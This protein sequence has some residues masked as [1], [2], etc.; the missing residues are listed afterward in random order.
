MATQPTPQELQELIRLYQQ[1]EG[2]TAS[3]ADNAAQLDVNLG[4]VANQTRRLLADLTATGE[5]FS[6]IASALKGSIQEF[7]KYNTFASSAKKSFSSLQSITSRLL[8][9]QSGYNRLSEKEIVNLKKKISLETTNLTNLQNSVNLTDEQKSEVE[10]VLTAMVE[11][12][13]LTKKR[14]EKEKEISK[15][16][17]ITGNALKALSKIPGLSNALDTEEA[18]EDM[19]EYADTLKSSGKDITSF[20]NK[21]KIAGKGFST[22][23]GGLKTSLKDP[24]SLITFFVA[25]AFK[26][27]SQAVELGKSL[28][29][30]GEGFRETLSNIELANSNINVTTE[31]LTKAFSEL[32]TSTGFAYKFSEDQ[33]VTQVKLT[34]QVG[35]QADEAAQIQRY[36]VLNN[37]TSE[38]TYSNFVKGLV[39]ARNQFKVGIDFKATL[40]EAVKVSGQLAANLGYNP[41][42]IAKAI[43]TAK[44]FGMTLD[45]VAKS[46]ESL[47][48]WESSIDNELKAEL[49]TGKQLNL[50][51]ARYAALTGDQV[52][53]AEELANQ[54]GTAADFTKM[55]VLQQKALA[56]SVGMTA[57]E[58]SNTLRKREE[59]I[60][61]GKSLAQVTEE[62]AKQAL[63]RQKAQDKFN[64]GIEKLTSLIGNL[65]AGPLGMFLDIVSDIFSIV[66]KIISKIQDLLG[67]GIAKTLIGAIGGFLVGGPIGALIGGIGGAAS[68]AMADDMMSGYGER[69]L[70]T[71]NGAVALN[72]SDTVIAGTNLFKGDDVASFPKGALN[73]GGNVDLTPM[74]AAINEVRA[75]VDRLYNKNTTINMDSKQ[76]GSTLVQS[77]YKLA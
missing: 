46:G 36:G 5:T 4:R 12:S 24:V 42:R 18:L 15:A 76:V 31:N 43:V 55:N 63:E 1:V 34:E 30:A 39:A 45:Q 41:E 35:L 61:S 29:T 51:K 50:E 2:L 44:A 60:A 33:L 57:D 10:G 20:G 27:N 52:T 65:L 3:Q 26:A 49:L 56:E 67:S 77:S 68:A 66:T 47:L 73:L 37:Q 64:K 11:L 9:D 6:S 28:G 13:N 17:G 32:S 74:I 62:E 58:L 7:S 8:N 75:S 48:N 16:T 72:N 38:K 59:A 25:Q 69:T 40:A 53:L 71:P 22:A 19:K 21:L 14:L 23:F 70:L 54:V